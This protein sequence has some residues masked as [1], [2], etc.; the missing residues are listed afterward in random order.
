VV[1]R[2]RQAFQHR[3]WISDFHEFARLVA[4]FLLVVVRVDLPVDAALVVR[5]QDLVVETSTLF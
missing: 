2:F 5:P 4:Q 3:A 1:L